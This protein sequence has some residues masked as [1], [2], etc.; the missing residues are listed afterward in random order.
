MIY[1][2]LRDNDNAGISSRVDKKADK[3]FNELHSMFGGLG[4]FC[5]ILLWQILSKQC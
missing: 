1:D 2:A 5:P 4:R 3:L